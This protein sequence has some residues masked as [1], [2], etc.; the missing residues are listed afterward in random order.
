MYI[1]I[2]FKIKSFSM[3]AWART[4]CKSMFLPPKISMKA[5]SHGAWFHSTTVDLPCAW[6]MSWLAAHL[7]HP[8]GTAN[9]I[10]RDAFQLCQLSE[11]ACWDFFSEKGM[12]FYSRPFCPVGAIVHAHHAIEELLQHGA[13]ICAHTHTQAH[14]QAH[15]STWPLKS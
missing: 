12:E 10:F 3:H 2:Y 11:P 15:E 1:Y 6:K 14:A 8:K 9:V 7:L 5:N 13:S 4:L